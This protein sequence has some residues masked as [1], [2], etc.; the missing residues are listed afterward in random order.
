MYRLAQLH[1]DILAL[2]GHPHVSL[3]K[4]TKKVQGRSSLLAQRELKGVLFTSLFDSFLNII[5]Y[6][7]KTVCRTEPVDPLVR[8]LVV[9]VADPVI[10]PLAGVGE[11]SK[12]RV[13]Q[14]L[15]PH[16]LPEPLDFAQGHGVVGSR[17]DV[18]DPLAFENLLEL[19]LAPPGRELPA[20]I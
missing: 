14:K 1:L 8:A 6:A 15:G 10:E 5:G 11:R 9:V 4:F 13:L 19:G 7:V 20:I 3:S 16:R 12:H 17:T 18:V 2:A